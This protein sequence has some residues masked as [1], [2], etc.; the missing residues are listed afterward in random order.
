MG[1]EGAWSIGAKN[2]GCR[3][4]TEIHLRKT[5]NMRLR[6]GFFQILEQFEWS[7]ISIFILFRMLFFLLF[8]LLKITHTPLSPPHTHAHTHTRMHTYW[9]LLIDFDLIKISQKMS[10][11][12]CY[13]ETFVLKGDFQRKKALTLILLS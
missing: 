12:S 5:Q 10:L 1:R 13:K 11:N 4:K 3:Q 9:Y 8:L 2:M 6:A 7:K